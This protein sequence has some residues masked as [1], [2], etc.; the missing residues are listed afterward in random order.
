MSPAFLVPASMAS[1]GSVMSCTFVFASG[2]CQA[3]P[4]ARS[5]RSVDERSIAMKTK[6]SVAKPQAVSQASTP[7]SFRK[8]SSDNGGSGLTPACEGVQRKPE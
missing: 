8:A 1:P 6:P 4:G 7:F 5:T 3:M 2:Y